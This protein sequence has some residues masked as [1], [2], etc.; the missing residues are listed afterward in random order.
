MFVIARQ[1]GRRAITMAK[2]LRW[3]P[4]STSTTRSVARP[5]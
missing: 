1:S 2:E 3:A 4:S 5:R